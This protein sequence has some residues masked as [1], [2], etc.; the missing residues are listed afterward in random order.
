MC[1]QNI[2]FKGPLGPPQGHLWGPGGPKGAPLIP[3]LFAAGKHFGAVYTSLGSLGPGPQGPGP[4]AR[5]LGAQPQGPGPYGPGSRSLDPGPQ[6]P[7]PYGPGLRPSPMRL[8]SPKMAISEKQFVQDDFF[9][10]FLL[11]ALDKICLGRGGL[12]T[13]A[14][15]FHHI[16]PLDYLASN[17][18][19]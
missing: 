1:F 16:Q 11:L 8:E 4:L 6:G 9:S 13:E 5:S 10:Q 18:P 15:I 7:G 14:T 3:P 19:P 12:P 2:V 17:E